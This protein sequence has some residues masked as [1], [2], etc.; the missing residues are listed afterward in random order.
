[1]ERL[2]IAIRYLY[3][4]GFSLETD[5]CCLIFDYYQGEVRLPDK[6]TYV[7]CTHNHADHYNPKIF[8]WQDKR[9]G[10]Q[11]I[12]SYDLKGDPM[13]PAGKDN[14][15]F[16]SPGEE[17][18]IEEI[19]VKAYG[20]TDEGVSFLVNCEGINIFHAGDLNWWHWA[21]DIPAER[22]KA[23]QTFKA[24]IAKIEGSSVD[25]AFF[26]VDPRLDANYYLGAELFIQTIRPR[27][28]VPMHFWDDPHIIGQFRARMQG[29]ATQII[30]FIQRGQEIKL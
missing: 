22:V 3:H 11:Y 26:P 6:K 9:P 10:I 20:S 12:L 21:E 25:I 24:E 15:T 29:S 18:L 30:Q 19:T 23:E 1:M 7:F 14:L 27:Y 28:L 16:L 4:S 13:V 8:A 5:N 2:N 17:R